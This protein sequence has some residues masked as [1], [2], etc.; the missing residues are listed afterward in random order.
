MRSPQQVVRDA[1]AEILEHLDLT[2]DSK[3]GRIGETTTAADAS[4]H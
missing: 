4:H 1:A 3:E 2:E